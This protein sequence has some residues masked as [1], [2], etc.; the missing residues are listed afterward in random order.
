MIKKTSI[1]CFLQ[2]GNNIWIFTAYKCLFFLYWFGW[3]VGDIIS[4]EFKS[5]YVFYLTTWAAW[6]IMLYIGVSFGVCIHGIVTRN[7]WRCDAR[8]KFSNIVAIEKCD[9]CPSYAV[10]GKCRALFFFERVLGF[11]LFQRC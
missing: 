6:A 2:W 1:T 8:K 10:A 4:F 3:T 9:T 11:V 5:T 7:S